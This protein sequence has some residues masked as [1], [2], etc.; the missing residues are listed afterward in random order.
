MGGRRM[1]YHSALLE[2]LGDLKELNLYQNKGNITFQYDINKGYNSI[3]DKANCI[4]I[5]PAWRDGYYKF[6]KRAGVFNAEFNDYL[7]NIRIVIEMFNKPSFVVMGKHMIKRLAPDDTIPIKLHGY[8]CYVGVYNSTIKGEF[9][10]NYDF[11][12]YISTR[13]NCVLDFCCGYGNTLRYFKRFVAS[14][15]NSKCVYY[16]AKKYMDYE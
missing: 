13:F 9:K 1:I 10:T 7:D 8:G 14:D 16:V 12:E 6:A 11:M 15:V 2:E 3:F 4:Y 5:E